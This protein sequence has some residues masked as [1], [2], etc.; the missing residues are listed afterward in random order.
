MEIPLDNNRFIGLRCDNKNSFT[1]SDA[2]TCA[3]H[4]TNM[5]MNN[6]EYTTLKENH[7]V[8]SMYDY[9]HFNLL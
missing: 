2:H 3:K 5:A 1:R 8:C 6:N 7:G 9:I 4:F